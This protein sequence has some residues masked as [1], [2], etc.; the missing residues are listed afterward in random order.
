M[1][2][3]AD[4]ATHDEAPAPLAPT[5]AELEL[6]ADSLIKN[7]VMAASAAALVPIPLFDIAAI[8]AVQVRLIQKL[9][10]MYDKSFSEAAVSNTIT[11]LAGGVIG[12]SAGVTTAISLTKLIPGVGWMFGMVSMPVVAGGTTY[13]VGRVFL[14]HFQQGGSV[15]DISVENVRG[16]YSEQVDRGKKLAAAAKAEIHKRTAGTEQAA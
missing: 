13:A 5:A 3:S 12:H 1:A 11:A 2:K 14:R 10:A 6:K 15:F 4:L 7:H 16:Y 9:A 8:T